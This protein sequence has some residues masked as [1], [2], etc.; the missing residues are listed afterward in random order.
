MSILR[1]VLASAALVA[2][3]AQAS[4]LA[5]EDA[6]SH[7]AHASTHTMIAAGDIRW[8]PAPPQLPKGTEQ[9]V[10]AGDP[11]KPGV[12]IIRARLP[13]GAV[14]A[15]HWHSQAENITVLQGTFHIGFGDVFDKAK[16]KPVA[17]G[18]FLSMPANM[19]HFVWTEG[20]TIIQVTANGPFD[21]KFVN[22]ED[23]PARQAMR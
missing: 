15:P 17:A 19:R 23:D 3:L 5:A 12:F 18:G 4:G 9:A 13:D 2:G 22:P 14:I 8:S 6:K 11:G 1:N 16:A 21:I 10:L 20:P 7:G